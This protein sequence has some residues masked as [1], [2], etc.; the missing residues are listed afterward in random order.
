MRRKLHWLAVLLFVSTVGCGTRPPAGGNG[1]GDATQFGR[2]LDF[3]PAEEY[4]SV[5][6]YQPEFVFGAGGLPDRVD[7]SE[8]GK[9]PAPGQQGRQQSCTAWACAYALKTYHE[10][11]EGNYSP[12]SSDQVFSPAFLYYYTNRAMGDP[13]RCVGAA[14]TTLKTVME[15]LQARG[16]PTLSLMPY[17][18]TQCATPPSEQALNEA[19]KYTIRDFV[20]LRGTDDVRRIL[21][22]GN[23]VI[24]GIVVGT[25]FGSASGSAWTQSQYEADLV[26]PGAGG[27]AFVIVGYD[28]INR[29]FKVLNSWG[30]NWGSG[31][32]WQIS[33]DVLTRAAQLVSSGQTL[34][35]L[36]AAFDNVSPQSPSPDPVPQQPDGDG[37]AF[38]NSTLLTP[39]NVRFEYDRGGVAPRQAGDSEPFET[40]I[41]VTFDLSI[42]GQLTGR[43]VEG[44]LTVVDAQSFE[45]LP[46]SDGQYA[47]DGIVAA[48]GSLYV[49][50]PMQLTNLTLFLPYSEFDL[51]TGDYS[52]LPVLAVGTS[53]GLELS[54]AAEEVPLDISITTDDSDAGVPVGDYSGIDDEGWYVDF[55]IEDADY[56][57]AGLTGPQ[58]EDRDEPDFF[59]AEDAY[60]NQAGQVVFVFDLDNYDCEYVGTFSTRTSGDGTWSCGTDGPSGTWTFTSYEEYY[61]IDEP[62]DICL[63]YPELCAPDEICVDYPELC[64][65]PEEFCGIYPLLC[66]DVNDEAELCTLYPE[67]CP[68]FDEEEQFCL[69]FPE[70][71]EDPGEFDDFCLQYPE[72]CEDSG[73][74][75]DFCLQYPELCEDSGDYEDICFEFPEL[76]GDFEDL[77][78]F[79]SLYPEFCKGSS[80]P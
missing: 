37:D 28:D 8:S 61:D 41:L 15:L 27:H 1:D 5:A 70:L 2:G 13:Q 51:P 64:L 22:E 21:A 44:I 68:G 45:P 35:E 23:P 49:T 33:Y 34:L 77:E 56:I 66:D 54:F 6:V 10:A 40:G 47:Y 59:S 29:T 65:P 36:W 63:E 17:N 78:D 55:Y 19:K 3:T 11:V 76:C 46:D 39:T 67:L 32:Y 74:F 52:L 72:L 73:E 48:S 69:E 57:H 24:I 75:D 53:D 9:F 43:F 26:D 12:Q 30:T 7:L 42:D 31:G 58:T 50:G 71:C 80:G 79:C 18:E 16:V 25:T 38:E 4:G 60:F 14:V 62:E 20:T